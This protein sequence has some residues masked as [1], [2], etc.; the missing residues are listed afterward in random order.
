MFAIAIFK[1]NSFLSIFLKKFKC[2]NFYVNDFISMPMNT[3]MKLSVGSD[4]VKITDIINNIKQI[5]MI[6]YHAFIILY[7]GYNCIFGNQW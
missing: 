4:L 6:Y 1:Y 3:L 7:L 5:L 2:A